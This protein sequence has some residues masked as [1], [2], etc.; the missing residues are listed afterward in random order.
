MRLPNINNKYNEY[1]MVFNNMIQIQRQ[2]IA[3]GT[4]NDMYRR[5]DKKLQHC[6]INCFFILQVVFHGVTTFAVLAITAVI[7]SGYATSCQNLYIDVR[8]VFIDSPFGTS[9][10]KKCE[11][12]KNII[13][14]S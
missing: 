3:S 12:C 6:F 10:C 11:T 13:K 4:L 1:Y 5:T 9:K 7:T 14:Y 8:L 2:M